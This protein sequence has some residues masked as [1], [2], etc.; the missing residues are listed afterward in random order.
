MWCKINGSEGLNLTL[1]FVN[2]TAS[3]TPNPKAMLHVHSTRPNR[4]ICRTH[5]VSETVTSVVSLD[6]TTCLNV[7]MAKRCY[8]NMALALRVFSNQKNTRS[9]L[10]IIEFWHGRIQFRRITHIHTTIFSSSVT[11]A[12]CKTWIT[13]S[14]CEWPC[15]ACTNRLIQ[16]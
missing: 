10:M 8:S 6:V 2:A 7:K 9:V 11:V 5:C 3:S 4:N 16:W 12:H 14:T 15:I 13:L 1:I